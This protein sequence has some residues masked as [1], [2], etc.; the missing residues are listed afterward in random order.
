MPKTR[1]KHCQENMKSFVLYG[2]LMLSL[3]LSIGEAKHQLCVRPPD[4]KFYD[5]VDHFA[6]GVNLTSFQNSTQPSS[7]SILLESNASFFR[8]PFAKIDGNITLVVL[9]NM[10]ELK[11]R[12]EHQQITNLELVYSSLKSANFSD[13]RFVLINS[14]DSFDPAWVQSIRS[15]VSF[16]VF[17]ELE[18]NPIW[19]ELDG[20]NGDMFI[21]DRCG[22]LT[23]YIP[24]PL[25][26]IHTSQPIVQAA[27]LATYFDSPCKDMCNISSSNNSENDASNSGTITSANITLVNQS[28]SNQLNETARTNATSNTILLQV[29]QFFSSMF[30]RV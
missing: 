13:V 20:G 19:S 27:L 22:L 25:S 21:Y 14:K 5:I 23:Y 18:S 11:Q 15:Q 30:C 2:L 8:S 24:F 4:W 3:V 9:T 7:S 29:K 1:S 6:A 26:F 17:Q 28:N 12:N 16:E 10:N